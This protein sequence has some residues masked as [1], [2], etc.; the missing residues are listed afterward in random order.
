MISSFQAFSFLRE[1]YKTHLFWKRRW[2][3]EG[4]LFYNWAKMQGAKSSGRLCVSYWGFPSSKLVPHYWPDFAD[5]LGVT[6]CSFFSGVSLIFSIAVYTV[7]CFAFVSEALWTTNVFTIL[8]FLCFILYT[9]HPLSLW[10]VLGWARA[11]RGHRIVGI[12][13]IG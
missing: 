2:L 3:W 13:N 5:I 9:F 8:G 6:G 1:S 10:V 12:F 7:Q 4:H 11:W